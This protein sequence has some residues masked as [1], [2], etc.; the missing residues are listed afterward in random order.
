MKI[1]RNLSVPMVVVF[2]LGLA[3]SVHAERGDATSQQQ[4]LNQILEM[5]KKQGMDPKTQ[6]QVENMMKGR[7]QEDATRKSGKL[8]KEQ[9][10]FEAEMANNGTAQVELAG[11]QY[12]LKVIKCVVRDRSRGLL[13]IHARQA[14][15]KDS[16]ELRVTG[17]SSGEVQFS[18]G[19]KFYRSNHRTFPFNGETLE[20]EGNG[21]RGKRASA[22]E[23]PSHMWC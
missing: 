23:I 5:M 11:K 20:W 8:K 22:N 4:Q 19:K 1:T 21:I 12:E 17:S 14:P 9:Q 3:G 13:S 15:G 16:G 7:I 10:A 18:L 2:L 6:K